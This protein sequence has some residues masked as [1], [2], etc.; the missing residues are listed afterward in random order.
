M[1]KVFIISEIG[2]NHNGDLDL[3]KKMIK[4]SKDCGADSVKFQKR[5]IDLVYDKETL[6]SKRESPWGSTFREQKEGLEFNEEQY[7][8]IDKYCKQLDVTWFS[9]AWD[10]NSL[11]FLEKFSSKYNKIASAMII[12]K[13]FL[14][15]VAM[16]KKYTFISTGM[17]NF[18]IIDNAVEIF[19][20]NNCEFELMHCISE[21]PFDDKLANLNMINILKKRYGC[22]VG[23]SGHEKGGLAI[24]YAA[25]ALGISSLERHFTLDRNLYGSDQSAS[26]TPPTFKELIGGI[27]KIEI[28]LHGSE[29]KEI[30]DI[31]KKVAKKLRAHIKN[32]DKEFSF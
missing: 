16:Q 32:S 19:S 7:Q 24:S 15:E 30:L 4:E 22:N 5:D 21:Y 13:T 17:S 12:D 1:S 2:I 26:I 18:K 6:A 20:K 14:N 10:L 23:Y 27:R 28:A 31:E 3:A 9:S 25:T 29:N 8:E 11:K